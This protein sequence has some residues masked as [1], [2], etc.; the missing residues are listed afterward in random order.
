MENNESVSGG[1]DIGE[2]Y[3]KY[4][5]VVYG[6]CLKILWSEDEAWDATQDIFMKLHQSQDTL[7]KSGSVLY[8]LHRTTTNHCIS[9]LR[10]K[11]GVAYQEEA[12]AGS[13][14]ENPERVLAAK[15]MLQKLFGPWNKVV[16]EIIVYT[17]I[18]GYTQAEISKLTG[19]GESTIRKYLTK[20]RRKAQELRG[21]LEAS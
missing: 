17:Y 3:N 16:R 20:F 14:S 13:D 1:L 2:V 11:R 12:H 19:L 8:W 4:A 5:S 9:V 15:Q 18:D 6:R 7:Q 21:G 10:R